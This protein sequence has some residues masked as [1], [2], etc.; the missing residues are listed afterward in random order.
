V[1]STDLTTNSDT[2][3]TRYK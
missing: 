3:L 1:F 2:C